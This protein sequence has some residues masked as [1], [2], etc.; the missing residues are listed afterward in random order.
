MR[1]QVAA[2]EAAAR[3]RSEQITEQVQR[4]LRLRQE[5]QEAERVERDQ[6]AQQDRA[7]IENLRKEVARMQMAPR[8]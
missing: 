1:K 3:E 8:G 5:S 2:A 6:K 4:E 7:T